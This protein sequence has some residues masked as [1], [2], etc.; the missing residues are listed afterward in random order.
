MSEAKLKVLAIGNSFSQD[1]TAYL[2]DFAKS[3]GVGMQVVNLYIGGCSL[4]THWE[5]AVSGEKLYLYEKN[6]VST[7]EYVSVG[8]TLDSEDWDFVTLQ[9]Q[10]SRSVD[11]GTYNPYLKNLSRFV[12]EKAPCAE[13]VIFQT[14]AYEENS[15]IIFEKTPYKKQIDMFG[16]LERAY[17]KAA[18][19]LGDLRIIPGGKAFQNAM[20][21][22]FYELFRDTF[23]ASIPHGRYLLSAV[24]FETLTGISAEE[25]NF[26]PQIENAE[27][28]RRI[29]HETVSNLK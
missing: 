12:G 16:A 27:F 25:A 3:A 10:S 24:W 22:G 15:E 26:N 19:E 13:Q 9:Q 20:A 6:G 14:W 17:Y 21:E 18:A 28:F 11:Y 4:Q 2:H 1:A 5:N 23:H 29:A 8:D 7:E